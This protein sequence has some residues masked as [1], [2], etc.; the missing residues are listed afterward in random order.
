MIVI[1]ASGRRR[2]ETLNLLDDTTEDDWRMVFDVGGIPEARQQHL[3]AVL[4]GARELLEP[5][6]THP[7]PAYASGQPD[8]PWPERETP[9]SETV[10]TPLGALAVVTLAVVFL[11]FDVCFAGAKHPN[12]AKKS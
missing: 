5:G 11:F 3:I 9:A 2:R 4:H 1:D 12:S 8:I 10:V 6:S 7:P